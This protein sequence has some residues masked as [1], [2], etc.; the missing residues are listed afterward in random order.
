MKLVIQ[1]VK[2][3]KVTV[4]GKTVGEIYKGLLVFVGIAPEDT[5]ET[6]DRYLKK[7]VDFRIFEDEKGKTNLSLLDV[8][9]SCCWFLSLP[10]MPTVRKETGPALSRP[11][12]RIWLNR[13]MSICWKKPKNM[14]I[15]WKAA[16]LARRCRFPLSTTVPLPSSWISCDFLILF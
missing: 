16:S 10:S 15:W 1:R 3:A 13:S 8:G 2:E 7:L 9:E 4:E 11:L 14:S 6:A 5:K 12:P